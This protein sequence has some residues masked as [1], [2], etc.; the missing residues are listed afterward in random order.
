VTAV[1]VDT[2]IPKRVEIST[3]PSRWMIIKW[4]SCACGATQNASDVVITFV[5]APH[6]KPTYC[7]KK[8]RDG[9]RAGA[10]RRSDDAPTAV[11]AHRF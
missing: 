2:A 6:T 7:R 8:P 11:I 9:A 10:R 3:A 5:K 4:A 1:N